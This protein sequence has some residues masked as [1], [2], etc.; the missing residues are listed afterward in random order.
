MNKQFFICGSVGI[1]MLFTF[2][3]VAS[4]LKEVNR[5]YDMHPISFGFLASLTLICYSLFHLGISSKLR[6]IVIS[7]LLLILLVI[8]YYFANNFGII[9]TWLLE[10]SIFNVL[11]TFYYSVKI[12][13]K[14]EAKLN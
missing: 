12:H 11:I 6:L 1:V 7:C 10:Y 14:A 2:I 13:F 5:L 4:Y 8:K 3:K 9:V